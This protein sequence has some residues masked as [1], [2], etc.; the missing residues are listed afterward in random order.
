MVSVVVVEVLVLA[1]KPEM[2]C[3]RELRPGISFDPM[4]MRG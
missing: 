3:T 4:P 2:G 1:L